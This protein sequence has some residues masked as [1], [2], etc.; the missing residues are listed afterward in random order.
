MKQINT[1]L[2]RIDIDRLGKVDI[3]DHIILDGSKN[4][5]IPEDFHHIDVDL[6]SREVAAWKAA[7]G[8]A[9]VDSSP[10]GAGRNIELLN[11][12]SV[13]SQVPFIVTSGFHKL[14]Y[15]EKDHWLNSASETEIAEI[16]FAECEEG[17]LLNDSRPHQS[18]RSTTKANMLKIGVDAEGISPLGSKLLNAVAKTGNLLGIPLMIHT[19]PGVPF[20]TL[21]DT[22]ESI[23]FDPNR[24]IICHMGKSLDLELHRALAGRGYY[25][26][27]DEMVRPS[28]SLPK[29]AST[30]R[31]LF[32]EGFGGAVLFA[33]DLA[34]RG[35]WSCYGGSP[36]L[37]FLITSLDE[38]L[39]DL[40]ISQEIL[41]KI[42]IENPQTLFSN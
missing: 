30:I 23:K 25:L 36:G 29:L 3:H 14:S 16:L 4:E 6:I 37:P 5:T 10:I 15:Y 26:E 17:V 32:D 7:G 1:T 28:P 21:V 11:E 31:S 24:V 22:L 33:G 38:F 20:D 18:K 34:R 40:G 27:F 9:I 8:G 2:G 41:D 39:L 35:Y 12:T 19:E 13:H 42:W